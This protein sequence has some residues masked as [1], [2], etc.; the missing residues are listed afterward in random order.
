[1]MWLAENVGSSLIAIAIA[2]SITYLLYLFRQRLM[3]SVQIMV[4]T[5]APTPE[6]RIVITNHGR[7]AAV[8]TKLVLSHHRNRRF[9]EMSLIHHQ[10]VPIVGATTPPIISRLTEY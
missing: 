10:A 8:I 3:V 9:F 7:S 1:M 2:L 5:T 6:I 4:E